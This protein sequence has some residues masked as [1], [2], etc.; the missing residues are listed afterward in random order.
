MNFSSALN[1]ANFSMAAAAQYQNSG[2]SRENLF[3]GFR[4]LS[5]A[6]TTTKCG[7]CTTNASSN[8]Y[9]CFSITPQIVVS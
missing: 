7:V 6:Y 2:D 9:D 3:V 8:L 1:N 4:R 5:N